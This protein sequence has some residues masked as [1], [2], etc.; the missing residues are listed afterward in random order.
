MNKLNYNSLGVCIE[1]LQAE[2]AELRRINNQLRIEI[3]GR[4]T[5]A[6]CA[7]CENHSCRVRNKSIAV[8][9]LEPI[10]SDFTPCED[11][12]LIMEHDKEEV[13]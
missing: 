3:E 8:T 5:C 13:K 11:I 7:H 10:C 2:N 6:D 9:E 4:L 1:I 12:K